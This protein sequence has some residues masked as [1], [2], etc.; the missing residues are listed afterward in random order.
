M[1]GIGGQRALNRGK[2]LV[3]DL[4]FDLVGCGLLAVG[5]QVFI[6]PNNIAPGGVSGIAVIVHHL[7]GAPIGAVSFLINLP[8]VALGLRFLGRSFTLKTFKSLII[9]SVLLDFGAVRLPAYRGDPILASLFGGV[10]MGAGLALVFLRGS[11][12]GG[13]DIASR[14]LQLSFPHLSMGRMMFLLDGVVLAASAVAFWNIETLLYGMVAIFC[15]QQVLDGILYGRDAG[16][17]AIIISR[18]PAAITHRIL[19]ELDRGVTYLEGRGAYS[20]EKKE[21]VLCAVS[22][23]QFPRL[24]ELIHQEDPEA[25]VINAEAGQIMGC[26]FR[27]IQEKK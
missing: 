1:K 3:A 25:F 26:G 12:T 17:M 23:Q 14:L 5:I 4:V 22:N 21:V 24:Q 2:E 7:L 27:P 18:R 9:L 16:R 15:S 8:L 6:A 13:T 10:A 11:T 20:G 19:A